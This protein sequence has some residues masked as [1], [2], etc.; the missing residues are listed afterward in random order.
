MNQQPP[1]GADGGIAI[2]FTFGGTGAATQHSRV[3]WLSQA[4]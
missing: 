2:L 1:A 3:D 4:A